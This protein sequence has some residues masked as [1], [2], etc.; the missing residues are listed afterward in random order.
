MNNSEYTWLDR[1]LVWFERY[2]TRINVYIVLMLILIVGA[3]SDSLPWLPV[4]V[5]TFIISVLIN[6]YWPVFVL[7]FEWFRREVEKKL[8]LTNKDKLAKIESVIVSGGE[9]DPG[10]LLAIIR[11]RDVE[12]A[13][14]MTDAYVEARL[15]QDNPI[16]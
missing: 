1:L 9:L 14:S 15:G 4:G 6:Q 3:V 2:V 7:A 10:Y 16:K 11:G 12:I 8:A 5:K 13:A